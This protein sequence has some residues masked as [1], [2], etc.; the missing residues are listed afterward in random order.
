MT[1]RLLSLVNLGD[2][3]ITNSLRDFHFF[4]GCHSW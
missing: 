4:V 2:F 3:R 1:I